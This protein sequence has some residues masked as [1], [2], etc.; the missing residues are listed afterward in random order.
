M[1][2]RIE[3]ILAQNL[4]RQFLNSVVSKA[5]GRAGIS[6]TYSSAHIPIVFSRVKKAFALE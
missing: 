6:M 3:Y 1:F 4:S 5:V 2:H